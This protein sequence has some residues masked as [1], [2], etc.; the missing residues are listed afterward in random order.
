MAITRVTQNMLAQRSLGSLQAGLSRMA[1]LHEELSS[2]RVLN[3]P[4]DSPTGTT[5]AMRLRD[6]LAATKQYQRNA[7]DGLAWLGLTDS[8]L[9]SATDQLREARDV[10][11]QGANDGSMG[12]ASRNALA[13]TVDQL[14]TSLLSSANTT[15]LGRPVFGGVTAGDKA[16]DATGAYV[17]EPGQ[18]TRTVGNGLKVRVDSDPAAAFGAAGDT[19]FDHLDALA[20]ALRANDTAA[21]GS[22]TQKV[23][24]DLDRLAA[25]HAEVGTRY[26]QVAAAQQKG[27][28][29]EVS[30]SSSL[31]EVENVDLPKV[32]VDLQLQQTAYQASLAATSRVLQPSL[33][34]FLR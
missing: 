5:T 22:A 19:V 17:G 28:D 31:S 2:G 30:V 18:V 4:S 21:V 34:D 9:Q 10:G 20:T 27:A 26:Q 1:R 11:L 25:A 15:Y 29:N 6:D 12:Q 8:T 7:Q 16:F 3:R 14:R 32:M 13:T 33:L 23:N 24:A